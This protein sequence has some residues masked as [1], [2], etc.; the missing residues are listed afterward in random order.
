MSTDDAQARDTMSALRWMGRRDV[1]L[2]SVPIPEPAADEA[3]IAVDWVGLCGSDLEEYL[4]GPVVIPGPVTLGH[5]I[6]G[7]VARPASDGSGPPA[8]TV[9]VVDV[10]TGCGHCFWCLS[11]DEGLCPDETVTGMDIDGGLAE[12]VVARASRLIAVPA[13]L[14]PEHAALAEPTAVSVRASRK[15]GPMRGRAAVIVGGG[16]IGLL[17]AQVLRH[18][19]AGV[20]V[21]IEP[22]D[23]RRALAE[24][25]GF[26]S[27]WAG[28]DDHRAAAVAALVPS[29]GPDVVIECSGAEGAASE[30]IRLV[31]PG[32]TV[33]LLSVTAHEQPIDTTA[34]MLAEK[35]VIGSSA[36]MWDDDV[37]PA[38]ELLAAGI[39]RAAPLITHAVPLADGA[40]AFETLADRTQNSLKVLVRVG[41]DDQVA[42]DSTAYR[43]PD[44]EGH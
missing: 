42:A 22:S 8:G 2:T 24:E 40:L 4:D 7:T 39:V 25:L 1:R 17:T 21:V 31:R 5:E 26:A 38:V 20:V 13:G 10:V 19:G 37:L 23:G 16:T 33:I 29:R 12:F 18:E 14:S 34:I 30:A 11:H 3:L 35:T 15:L 28:S 9:V 32:G 43:T 44:Q 27:V 41:R 36:H 6:V